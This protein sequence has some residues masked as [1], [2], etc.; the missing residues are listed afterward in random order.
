MQESCIMY[1]SE[2]SAIHIPFDFICARGKAK[3]EALIDSSATENFINEQMVWHLG[4]RKQEME[5]PHR[6]FNVDGTENL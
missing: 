6:V 2:I 5:T 1:I 4:I 3:E